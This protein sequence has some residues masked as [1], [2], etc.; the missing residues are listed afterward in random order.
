MPKEIHCCT[1]CG[2][3]TTNRSQVCTACRRSQSTAHHERRVESDDDDDE[4]T[5]D[6]FDRDIKAAIL[7]NLNLD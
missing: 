3:D 7:S 2:R 4:D 1:A 6:Y 5:D